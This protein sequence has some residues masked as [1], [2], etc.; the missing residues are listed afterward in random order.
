MADARQQLIDLYSAA[1]AGA[2]AESLTANAVAKIPLERRHRVWVFSI[3]KA[4]HPMAAAAVTTLRRALAEIA[5]GV[6]IAP[7]HKAAPV[8]TLVSMVG[9]HPVPGKRSFAAAA[10]LEQTLKKKRGAGSD[11]GVVLISGGASSLIGAPLRGMSEADLTHLYELLLAS[12]LDIHQMNAIR[13]RLSF[14]GAGRMALALAPAR[15]HCFAISDVPGDDIASIGSGPCVPDPTLAREIVALL[16]QSRLFQK[17]APSFRQYLLDAQRG[18]IPETPKD[19][20]PA[21]AHMTSSVIGTN[22]TAL[23]AAATA[24]RRLGMNVVVN[25]QPIVGDATEAGARLVQTLQ[26]VRSSADANSVHCCIWGGETTL[27]LRNGAGP[28]GRCQHLALAAARELGAAP[29]DGISL[30]AAGSDGRDGTTDAAGAIVDSTTWRAIASTGRDPGASLESFESNAALA[31]V[32]ALFRP[33]STG[34][35]VMDLMIGIVK[36]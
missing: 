27:A 19:S 22:A 26:G 11:L 34:T 3:G 16:E 25:E 32:D 20:H 10:Q 35:N 7:A 33:G 17:I 15:T 14:W 28:G 29:I 1:I 6:I 2:D 23:S 18:V 24:A 30:L 31:S 21:F 36:A 12:G 4:A 8:G 5:G 13:K 9:D